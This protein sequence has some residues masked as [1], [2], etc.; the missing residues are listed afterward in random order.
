MKE[1][2]LE[3]LS[4]SRKILVVRHGRWN[5]KHGVSQTKL[6]QSFYKQEKSSMKRVDI[7]K[8][9]DTEFMLLNFRC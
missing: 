6:R 7:L 5:K 9:V 8:S 1:P 4:I 3:K 2:T